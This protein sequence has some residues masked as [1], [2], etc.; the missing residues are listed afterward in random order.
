MTEW[1]GIVHI[2]PTRNSQDYI[3]WMHGVDFH[4]LFETTLRQ[5][6][7]GIVDMILHVL[8]IDPFRT[9]RE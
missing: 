5:D 7:Q 1:V 6:T 4:N 2:G 9:R 3:I 8:F